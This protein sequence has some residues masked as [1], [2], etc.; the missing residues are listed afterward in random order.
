MHLCTCCCRRPLQFSNHSPVSQASDQGA[1]GSCTRP[2]VMGCAVVLP[3]VSQN[4]HRIGRHAVKC[5]VAGVPGL[6][7]WLE[8]T[9]HRA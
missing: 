5:V 6:L 4:Y 2:E 1:L 9:A 7:I 8:K 3:C